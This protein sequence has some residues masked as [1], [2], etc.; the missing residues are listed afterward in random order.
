MIIGAAG[1]IMF[2]L[3]EKH[4]ATDP[5]VPMSIFGSQTAVVSYVGTLVHGLMLW[6][7]LYYLPLYFEAVKEYSPVIAGVASFPDSFSIAPSAIAI[8]ILITR[9]GHYRWTIWLGWILLT[10]GMGLICILKSNTSIPSWVFLMSVSGLGLGILFPSLI[11]AIQASA[12]PGQ[13]AMAVTMCSFFR[14]FGQAIGVAIGGSIFQNRM[15][16][17]LLAYPALAPYADEYSK[18]AAALVEVIR[19]MAGG[20]DKNDLQNA[21]TDSL[22]I[23]WGVCCALAGVTMFLSVLTKEYDLNQAMQTDQGLIKERK[24]GSQEEEGGVITVSS[25][26][27]I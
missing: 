15:H 1:L 5:I 3:Y 22:R 11:F 12:K 14:S 9:T 13:L 7:S 18:D 24:S 17:N 8:G 2:T 20:R 27:H 23:I 6:C 16:A 19:S 21:Y 10:L 4:V 25:R 26:C